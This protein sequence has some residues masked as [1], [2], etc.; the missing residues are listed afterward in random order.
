VQ[1]DNAWLLASHA[2][3]GYGTTYD[4]AVGSEG[5]DEDKKDKPVDRAG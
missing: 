1:R 3:G 2:A 5:L 4:F